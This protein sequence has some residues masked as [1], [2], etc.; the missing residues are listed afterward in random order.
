MDWNSFC[1]QYRDDPQFRARVDAA[2]ENVQ[3]AVEAMEAG[4]LPDHDVNNHMRQG[5]RLF[6]KYL[7]YALDEF[8]AKF[9]YKPEVLG[10][11]VVDIINEY[12]IK[13][14]VVLLR[15]SDKPRYA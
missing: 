8:A 9:K 6:T 2:A 13:E 10:A 1:A 15:D 4:R 11:T 14:K 7:V 5:L 12:N 3:D